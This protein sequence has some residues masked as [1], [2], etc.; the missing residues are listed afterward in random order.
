MGP[1]RACARAGEAGPECGD[2]GALELVHH[3]SLSVVPE[4]H[5]QWDIASTYVQEP[6]F[7]AGVGAHPRGAHPIPGGRSPANRRL[8]AN[9]PA[10]ASSPSWAIP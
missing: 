7:F 8:P 1:R 5:Y 6:P 2:D 4:A 9:W 3:I 10:P